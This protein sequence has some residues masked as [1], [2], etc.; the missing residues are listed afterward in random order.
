MEVGLRK[1]A[2]LGDQGHAPGPACRGGP[3][4]NRKIPPMPNSVLLKLR[5]P[6]PRTVPLTPVR[7]FEFVMVVAICAAVVLPVK[8]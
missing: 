6:P 7:L 4:Q 3:A 2:S 8:V 5:P 1:G